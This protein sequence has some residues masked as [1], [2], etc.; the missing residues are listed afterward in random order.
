MYLSPLTIFIILIVLFLA[1]GERAKEIKR[2]N[3]KTKLLKSI[4]KALGISERQ[5]TLRGYTLNRHTSEELYSIALDR[6]NYDACDKIKKI[7]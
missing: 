3:A 1:F 5:A 2:L 4:I 7:W 6:K